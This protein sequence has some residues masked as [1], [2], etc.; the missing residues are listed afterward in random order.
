M[1]VKEEAEGIR[2]EPKEAGKMEVK[3][4]VRGVRIE[5]PDTRM[6]PHLMPAGSIGFMARLLGFV[7]TGTTAHGETTRA[8]GRGTT[9]TSSPAQT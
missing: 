9:G 4:E 2:P 7:P 6:G 3:V 1:A 5:A 8:Q